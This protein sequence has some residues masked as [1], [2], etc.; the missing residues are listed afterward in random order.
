MTA[1]L[2]RA[3]LCRA[4]IRRPTSSGARTRACRSSRSISSSKQA[5]VL[6][7]YMS[8]PGW[9]D[10]LRISV[11]TDEQVDAC[12]TLLKIH[13][14]NAA[15]LPALPA[16]PCCSIALADFA[17]C[18]SCSAG[19]ESFC[20]RRGP[21]RRFFPYGRY[22]RSARQVRRDRSRRYDRIHVL[23]PDFPA[24]LRPQD[25]PR[26]RV[27][28]G[29][30]DS[31]AIWLLD[32]AIALGLRCV[33]LR[34]DRRAEEPISFV[35]PAANFQPIAADAYPTDNTPPA[36]ADPPTESLTPPPTPPTPD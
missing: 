3:G 11:G 28:R 9:G 24:K 33:W 7:R 20:R 29:V 32:W 31:F 19:A 18:V 34:R 27:S 5:G 25:G 12:L 10:G 26:P 36:T 13:A 1:A 23:R 35:L 15:S 22:D 16:L 8:Y 21:Y 4:S 2:A 17:C 6:V 30:R 14:S